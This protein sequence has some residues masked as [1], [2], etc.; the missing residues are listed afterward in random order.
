[1][2][3]VARNGS[4]QYP[5][6]PQ[7]PHVPVSVS[8]WVCPT[9]LTIV[10]S[11]CVRPGVSQMTLSASAPAGLFPHLSLGTLGT[12]IERIRDLAAL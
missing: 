11:Q 4:S 7:W 10:I 2:V 9:F 5:N 8:L 1:M 6:V 3:I 12:V